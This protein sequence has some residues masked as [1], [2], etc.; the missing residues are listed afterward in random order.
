MTCVHLQQLYNLCQQHDFK[1]G[2]SDL[3]R[4][5]CRQCEAHEVC[6]STLMD[7]CEVSQLECAEP[8]IGAVA[9]ASGL[10][11]KP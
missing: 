10:E 9:G 4:L 1:L 7:Q 8:A 11:D 3:V 6:P 5:V 2:G